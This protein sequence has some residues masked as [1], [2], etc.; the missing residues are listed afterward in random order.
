MSRKFFVG[1]IGDSYYVR[2]SHILEQQEMFAREDTTV[3]AE[4]F[5]RYQCV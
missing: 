4:V 5:F 2:E 3:R 1:K